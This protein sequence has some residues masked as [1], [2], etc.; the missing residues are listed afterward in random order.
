MNFFHPSQIETTPQK[1]G[2]NTEKAITEQNHTPIYAPFFGKKTTT[3]KNIKNIEDKER[4]RQYKMSK[5]R[6]SRESE[7]PGSGLNRA[8]LENGVQCLLSSPSQKASSFHPVSSFASR[9]PF[10]QPQYWAS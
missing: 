9:V 3:I 6:K 2:G 4:L 7:C 8:Y 1:G 10:S 5:S